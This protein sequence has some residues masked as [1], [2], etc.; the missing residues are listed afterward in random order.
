MFFFSLSPVRSRA[1]NLQGVVRGSRIVRTIVTLFLLLRSLSLSLSLRARARAQTRNG[2]RVVEI[3]PFFHPAYRSWRRKKRGSA[4][5]HRSLV[6][7]SRGSR[8][9]ISSPSRAN[10]STPFF[11]TPIPSPAMASIPRS[12]FRLNRRVSR[13]PRFYNAARIECRPYPESL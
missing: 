11:P 12:H 4:R 5:N 2:T 8:A 1:A 13:D 6:P 9:N 7:R 3:A 10:T